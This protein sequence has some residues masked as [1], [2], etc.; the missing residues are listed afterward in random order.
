M[1][2]ASDRLAG[3]SERKRALLD[4]RL[5]RV[6]RRG[7]TI[8]LR[9]RDGT[10]LPLSFAQQRLWFL[11]LLAPRNPVYNISLDVELHGDL[12][13]E[14]MAR[15]LTEIGRRHEVL[16][17]SFL[18][19][20]EKPVQIIAPTLAITLDPIDISD[21][22]PA[23]RRAEAARL[24]REEA[25]K[26]FDL[27]KGPLYRA[28][29]VRLGD[30]EHIVTIS[31]HHVVSDGWS[32]GIL[33]REMEILYRAFLAGE[34][35]PL[36]ELPI[37][38]ADFAAWQRDWMQG[39]ILQSQLAY[40][41]KQLGGLAPLEL[42]SDRPRPPVQTFRGAAILYS[43]PR[44]VLDGLMALS[45]REGATL[46]MTMLAA[47]KT[48]LSKCSGQED[49]AV[50][51][52]IAGRK[53]DEVEPLI[54]CF[55]NMLVMRTDLGGDPLFTDLV[56]RVRETTLGA[57]AHQDLPFEAI[58][59]VLRPE[60][61]TSRT[62]LFQ[63]ALTEQTAAAV[64][65]LSGLTITYPAPT[66]D[67]AR[68]DLGMNYLA[69][70]EGLLFGAEYSTDLF[71]AATIQRLLKH[72]ETLLRAIAEN[73][74]R[75]L[76]E[77]ALLDAG[78]RRQMVVEW[79]QTERDYP[80]KCVHQLFEEQVDRTPDGVAAIFEDRRLTYRELDRRSN[81]LARHL[82]RLGVGSE[83]LVGVCLERSLEMVVAIMGVLKAGG[84]YVPLDP[85][86][87]A[88]RLAFMLEDTQAA[89]LLTQ[90][91]LVASLPLA[92][93]A[94]VRLD[95]DW[96]AIEAGAGPAGDGR[97]ENVARPDGLA[98][99]IYTSGSTGKPKGVEL[100]HRGL[101]SLVVT[102]AGLFGVHRGS[103]ML[104][105]SAL[106]FDA[107]VWECFLALGR[108]AG[109]VLA[110]A[111]EIRDPSALAALLDR[112]RITVTLLP[113]SMLALLPGQAGRSLETLVV[114]GEACP[115]AVAAKWAGRVRLVNAYGP[116]EGTVTA[117]AWV[118]PTDFDGVRPLHIGRPVPNA[119][120]YVLDRGG[121][122][123]PIGVPGEL[124][125]GG[126]GLARG[127]LNR[128]E[129]TAE[130]FVPDPFVDDP[131]ARIYRT[132]DLVKY[133]PNGDIEFLG[134][135][136]SQVKIRGFRIELG[137]VEAVLG[138]HPGIKQVVVLARE[139]AP[140]Q[141]RLV[142]YLVPKAEAP[143][144]SDLR[145]FLGE[146][147]PAYM[148]PSAFVTMETLPI[149]PSGK[150]DHRA[151]P[152]PEGDRPNLDQEFVAPRTET[153]RVLADE[154]FTSILGLEEVG[155]RDNFFELGGNSLQATQL[156]A[157]ICTR[158]G[159]QLRLRSLFESPTVA[160]LAGVI[161]GLGVRHDD[162]RGS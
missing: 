129:L 59:N 28:S 133:L 153:E 157:R 75:R 134:R 160:G 68:F 56:K 11:D 9:P 158:F 145:S 1:A 17:T 143:T 111:A 92:R 86:Y 154:I 82:R 3:L 155:A 118:V 41:K 16:R 69:S 57:Y 19:V 6:D 98:Y 116:T 39:E 128:P 119:R 78:E 121:R 44:E 23:E 99:V 96:A 12:H 136:D 135:I 62:P 74:D 95:A 142:A 25:L 101:C 21:L 31:I 114:G 61:D 40:W 138:Q 46:Y 37:Q 71:D 80:L 79:N 36:L 130:K 65:E 89:V 29:L 51:C 63:V 76:S 87:P 150:V 15:V 50:G 73:P 110:P 88:E 34:P 70:P 132:G 141:K 8:P 43:V 102:Q 54:G 45:R 109:L 72:F 58:V 10:P 48:L 131:K 117:T 144:V 107:A 147:L 84:A 139:D 104:Q 53:R 22:P 94:T 66:S 83:T 127:Y 100:A 81:R 85:A 105:F 32:L 33:L 67:V 137:E 126:A 55:I 90:E 30:R 77:L 113:P 162:Y 140:G 122:P 91:R 14:V 103:R 38:Y 27:T 124:C 7:E 148:V 152:V 5:G 106:S 2:E 146:R 115:P 4:L 156:I 97:L 42:P 18:T 52:A 60:R 125:L 13:V 24:M 20:D 49:I 161:D 112:A 64:P 35:S 93:P 159:V 149:T 151:L 123:A 120:V 47:F 26:P 108:G